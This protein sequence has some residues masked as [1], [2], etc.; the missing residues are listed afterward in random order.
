MFKTLLNQNSQALYDA[1]CEHSS[2]RRIHT[3]TTIQAELRKLYPRFTV[4]ATISDLLS[5]A[6]AGNATAT[7]ASDYPV[8]SLRAFDPAPRRPRNDEPG[9]TLKD[10]MS[11][12]LYDYHWQAHDFKLFIIDEQNGPSGG[13]DKRFY[14]LGDLGDVKTVDRSKDDAADA[15]I[16]AAG[17]WA[18]QTSDGVWVFDFGHWMKD[19]ELWKVVKTANWDDV[20][21]DNGT[22]DAIMGDVLGFFDAESTY[23]EF[24]TPWKVLPL[25]RPLH[26]MIDTDM[27]QRGLI[28]HGS[29]G[30]GKT[31]TLKA[32]SKA[33]MAR[34][35][36]IPT[37]YVKTLVNRGGPQMSVRS[38][39]M[40]ARQT[41]PCLLLFEDID[42]L[43]TDQ[44]RS[45]FFNE[46]DG[47]ENNDGILMIASTNNRRY[48]NQS[49]MTRMLTIA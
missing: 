30:N 25:Y 9:G 26:P 18:A 40:K 44:V 12:A 24:G 21:L 33:L 27:L 34:P 13:C 11:F 43:V 16:M 2:G 29:P 3:D 48:K 47:L 46:V 37:L 22:K 15:L 6:T 45:Y 36:P 42:S 4:T 32:L 14:L 8:F 20:I 49:K 41:A 10:I 17:I 5:Y 39:F 1:Y 35:D 23:A 28:F 38:I 31:S 19:K 7:L